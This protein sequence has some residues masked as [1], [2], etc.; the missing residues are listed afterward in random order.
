M[1]VVALYRVS[2]KG[3][4]DSGLGIES[5]QQLVQQYCQAKGWKIVSEHFEEGVSG[6][7]PL[8]DRPQLAEAI[9]ATK[10]FQAEAVVVK[11][12]DR[13]A[14]DP[15]IHL[16]IERTLNKMGVR[17][18]S[19][20][21]EGTE[22]DDASSVFYRR[23]MAASSELEA[24][25]ISTRTKQAL[26]AKKARGERLGR[27]PFGFKVVQ[28]ELVGTEDY[29]WVVRVL[30]ERG[31]SRIKPR[32]QYGSAPNHWYENAPNKRLPISYRAIAE[33]LSAE[34]GSYWSKA[35]VARIV[36]QWG[37]LSALPGE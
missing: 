6:K 16:T 13:L 32:P 30:E 20:V 24:S 10:T 8:A 26:A 25:L 1:R 23:I 22:N 34:T 31:K 15:L 7:A 5:Q 9:A 27:P 29:K 36:T 19:T 3:Q 35:K 4:S 2:T 37:D 11:A 33:T 12:I 28:G 21:G 18:I 17:V 14:R